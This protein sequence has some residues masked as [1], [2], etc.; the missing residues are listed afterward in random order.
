[1]HAARKCWKLGQCQTHVKH[2]TPSPPPG[3]R[4]RRKKK[5]I[6]FVFIL[7]EMCLVRMHTLPP[8]SI[9]HT[10]NTNEHLRFYEPHNHTHVHHPIS[11][12]PQIHIPTI[13][14]HHTSFLA[15]I[16]QLP[17]YIC[18]PVGMYSIYVCCSSTLAD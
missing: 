2:T 5:M 4:R 7:L 9:L 17:T 18:N 1:M 14:S 13:H 15:R 8:L 12:I 11:H 6:F 10:A 3:L 16:T